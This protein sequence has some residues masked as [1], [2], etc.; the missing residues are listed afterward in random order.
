MTE[1]KSKES[2][3]SFVL[4]LKKTA[5]ETRRMLQEV[6][7]DNTMSQSKTFFGTNASR[8][9]EPLSTKMS[10]LDHR[11]QAQPRKTKQKFARLSLQIV[12]ETST[13]FVK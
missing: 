2:A 1:Y 12:G 13:M 3:P 7:G 5:A 9:D 8:T 10:V 4:I 6:F 11:W